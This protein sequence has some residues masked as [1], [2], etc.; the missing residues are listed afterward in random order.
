[1]LQPLLELKHDHETIENVMEAMSAAAKRLQ[2][3]QELSHE[4]F[5]EF[6]T[7]IHTFADACHHAKEEKYLF[8]LVEKK[9]IGEINLHLRRLE[10]EHLTSR[11]LLSRFDQFSAAYLSNRP[12]AR[13]S[14][15]QVMNEITALYRRHIWEEDHVF[16]PLL[17]GMLTPFEQRWLRD[18]F[19]EVEWYIGL[20]VHRRYEVLAD[21]VRLMAEPSTSEHLHSHV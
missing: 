16:L 5:Q 11:T 13:D 20:D 6:S 17:E 19:S 10:E 8:P 9:Q 18:K 15:V 14:L 2:H 7:F 12:G 3:G 4:L 21:K 1:M